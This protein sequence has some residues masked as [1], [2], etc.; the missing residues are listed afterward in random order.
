MKLKLKDSFQRIDRHLITKELNDLYLKE[1][2][3]Y[4]NGET[5]CCCFG[6]PEAYELNNV[7]IDFDGCREGLTCEQCW[8]KLEKKVLQQYKKI[9]K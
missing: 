8:D 3:K 4:F 9:N 7:Q 2:L 1:A 5:E 6:C